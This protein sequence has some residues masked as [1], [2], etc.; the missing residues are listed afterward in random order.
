MRYTVSAYCLIYGFT[1]FNL[2]KFLVKIISPLLNYKYSFLNS[3][4]FIR[5]GKGFSANK[6]CELVSF[7]VVSFFTSFP[8]DKVLCIIL[9]KLLSDKSL[10]GR[11]KLT[12]GVIIEYLNLCSDSTVFTYENVLH[13][14]V[15]GTPNESCLSPVVAT[16]FVEDVERYALTSFSSPPFIWIRYVEDTFCIF[17]P[18]FL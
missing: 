10:S 2:P 3:N 14:Q 16:I 11:T 7:N 4:E 6:I 1:D 9:E 13:R 8:L 15:F 17:N 5:K 12:V 18:D